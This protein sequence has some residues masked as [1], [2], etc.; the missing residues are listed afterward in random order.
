MFKAVLLFTVLLCLT[1]AFSIVVQKKAPKAIPWPFTRCGD[2]DWAIESMT[3]SEAP[4][5]GIICKIDVVQ[6]NAFSWALPLPTPRSAQSSS[7]SNSMGHRCTPRPLTSSSP[8][9][10]VTP[11]TTTSKT[12]F[13]ATSP[14]A[15]TLFNC[16][17]SRTLMSKTDAWLSPS[18][19]TD[20]SVASIS[21]IHQ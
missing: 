14:Q 13:P 16:S 8:T 19:S 17:S 10:K 5:R 15:P 12:P 2:G 21:S 1:S 18:K 20:S 6:M 11:S 3:L 4:K 9:R 7:L